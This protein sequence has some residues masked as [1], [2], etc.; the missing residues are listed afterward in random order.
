MNVI[1]IVVYRNPFS[2]ALSK[3]ISN[4]LSQQ[5][6][7]EKKKETLLLIYEWVFKSYL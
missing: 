7:V 4:T 2:R 1:F 6:W 3:V 5:I